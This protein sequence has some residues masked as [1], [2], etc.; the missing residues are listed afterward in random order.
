MKKQYLECGKIVS[1]HGVKGEVRVQPW[2][3]TPEYLCSFHTV[4]LQN[5]QVPLA[6]EQARVNKNMAL[7]KISGIDTLD[8]AAALRGAIL[9]I[10]RDDEP[11]TAEDGVF[12]IQ[13]LIGL[14]VLDADTGREWGNLT[15]VFSTGANDVYELTDAQGTTRLLPAITQVVLQTDIAAGVMYIRPLDGLFENE[16]N[17]DAD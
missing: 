2:C 3:D 17:S 11:S 13:D 9:C 12:F 8:A 16:V 1:T 10:N 14:R 15:D 7:L 4:Y 6:V 5:G